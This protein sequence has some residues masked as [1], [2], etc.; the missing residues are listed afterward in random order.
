[1]SERSVGAGGGL[2]VVTAGSADEVC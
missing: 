2:A 1:L